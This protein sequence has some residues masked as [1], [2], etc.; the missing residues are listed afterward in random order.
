MAAGLDRRPQMLVQ[1]GMVLRNAGERAPD[2]MRDTHPRAFRGTA[3]IER[4]ATLRAARPVERRALRAR[5]R[6][7]A[8]RAYRSNGLLGGVPRCRAAGIRRRRTRSSILPFASKDGLIDRRGMTH[9]PAPPGRV[10]VTRAVAPNACAQPLGSALEPLTHRRDIDRHAVTVCRQS[11]R[12]T[13]W[14]AGQPRSQSIGQVGSGR[15]TQYVPV[16]TRP[17]R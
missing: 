5:S 15:Y 7:L 13:E 11:R 4:L 9:A 17:A 16:S 6:V 12:P 2:R 10:R 1:R 3:Q 8:H 14:S